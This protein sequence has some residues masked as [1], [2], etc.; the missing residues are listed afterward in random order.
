M[1]D[2]KQ[3]VN[4]PLI[5]PEGYPFIAVFGLLAVI[6][7]F[8]HPLAGTVLLA[9]ALFVVSFFR[10]PKRP[11]PEGSGLVVCPADGKV[12]SIDVVD[13][14]R[15]L[16]RRMRKICIF[17]SP[18]NVHIN[19]VPVNGVIKKIV[20]MPGK[21]L[22]AYAPKASLEN[23][24][25]A[26]IME[27]DQGDD[28]LFIQIAGWLARR[29]VCHAKEGE[30]WKCGA[31]YGLIRFGSRVDVYIPESYKVDIEIGQM[32]RTGNTVL[33]RKA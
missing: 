7:F 15:F 20:Y 19:R 10:N 27:S 12:L 28:I 18:L 32:V 11:L 29:I 4:H 3:D 5:A 9:L 16:H 2:V 8:I 21:F 22:A 14:H 1:I 13:E 33:A 31:K 30:H 6:G 17:M 24:Q 26:V 23:E 25:N